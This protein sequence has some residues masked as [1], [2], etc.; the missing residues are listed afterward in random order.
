MVANELPN[1]MEQNN[2]LLLLCSWI[3]SVMNLEKADVSLPE[4]SPGNSHSCGY[5]HLE[6]HSFTCPVKE[7]NNKYLCKNISLLYISCLHVL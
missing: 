1:T 5:I 6:P 3:L 2:H 4:V 7:E